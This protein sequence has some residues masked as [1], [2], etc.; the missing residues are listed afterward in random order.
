MFHAVHD[1]RIRSHLVRF[2]GGLQACAA[3]LV[4]S[5]IL[6]AAN[7]TL[8]TELSPATHGTTLSII[9]F[10]VLGLRRYLCA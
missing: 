2:V 10:T 8:L 6:S 9:Q 4:D 3:E 1:A 7:L 5:C